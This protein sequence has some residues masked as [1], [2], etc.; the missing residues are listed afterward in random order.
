[1]HRRPT[2]C[3]LTWHTVRDDQDVPPSPPTPHGTG[4]L[5]VLIKQ[6]V[7]PSPDRLTVVQR[8]LFEQF[9]GFRLGLW[10]SGINIGANGTRI[11]NE[12]TTHLEAYTRSLP[13]VQEMDIDPPL[14]VLVH[15]CGE[16]SH[17]SA[18]LEHLSTKHTQ[19]QSGSASYLLPPSFPQ[20]PRGIVNEDHNFVTLEHVDRPAFTFYT[21]KQ[22]PKTHE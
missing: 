7:Q 2:T 8:R 14:I 5:D 3:G 6:I 21:V 22:L 19:G 16:L 12:N 11:A 13:L 4:L 9:P 20:H 15:F 10:C 1:M 17:H 18:H